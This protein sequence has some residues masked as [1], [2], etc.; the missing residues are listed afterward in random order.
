MTYSW[1]LILCLFIILVS[2]LFTN[3]RKDD[4]IKKM[5]RQLDDFCRLTGHEELVPLCLLIRKET[6]FCI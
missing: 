2:G 4:K 5:Q 1:L 3:S 6:W